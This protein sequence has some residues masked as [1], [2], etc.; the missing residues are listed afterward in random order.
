MLS[1]TDF[2]EFMDRVATD[3]FGAPDM[4]RVTGNE[5]RYGTNGSLK[6]DVKKGTW[7]DFENQQSGG[8]LALIKREKKLEGV[9]AIDYLRELG[10][11]VAP[12]EP[13][14]VKRGKPHGKPE[15]VAFYDYRDEDGEV[16]YQA[17][18][19]QWRLPDG[20][21]ERD[22]TGKI[23][24]TFRQRR[25]DGNGG[26]IEAKTKGPDG[27]DV[28]PMDRVAPLPYRLPDVIEAVSFGN[29]IIVVEGEKCAEHLWNWNFPAT[30][31]HGGA[32]KWRPE[33]I[34]IPDLLES[35]G[36]LALDSSDT[37]L[38]TGF[39]I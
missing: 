30:C 35:N 18:R 22:D 20:S 38:G 1:D 32:G 27:K 24:K 31:N 39:L 13:P 29:T 2:A 5:W 11:P 25:S 4:R 34:P 3:L 37:G 6:I 15:D 23:R 7:Y 17:V 19:R 10:C 21:F 28:G 8:V 12:R 33:L 36:V 14:E 16:R 9:D 26:W